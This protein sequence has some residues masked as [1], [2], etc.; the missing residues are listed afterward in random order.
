MTEGGDDAFKTFFSETEDG[1]Y[2]PRAVLIDLEP[3]VIDEVKTG[4]YR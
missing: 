3:T 4:T 2:V 1:K